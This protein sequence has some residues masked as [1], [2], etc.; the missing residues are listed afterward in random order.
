MFGMRG[1]ERRV[2][3][4]ISPELF[5]KFRLKLPWYGETQ[6]FIRKCLEAVVEDDEKTI[7][8]LRKETREE[9]LQG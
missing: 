1:K 5:E 9:V 4:R 8:E 3:A 2:C 7:K 6:L